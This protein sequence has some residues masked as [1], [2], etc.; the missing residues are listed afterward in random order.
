MHS[1]LHCYQCF[2]RSYGDCI[3]TEFRS[4]LFDGRFFAITIGAVPS[5]DFDRIAQQHTGANTPR[6]EVG[7]QFF[8]G[9]AGRVKGLDFSLNF[10]ADPEHFH[11]AN[12]RIPLTCGQAIDR[13]EDRLDRLQVAGGLTS[14]GDN[15]VALAN[16]PGVKR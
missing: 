11:P 2:D 15:I 16:S 5:L 8:H 7:N 10:V 14:L 3:D 13:G 1:L 9:F 6:F 12:K 4:D